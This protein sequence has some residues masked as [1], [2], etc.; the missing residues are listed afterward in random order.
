MEEE[1]IIHA[2]G[3]VYFNGVP[4]GPDVELLVQAFGVP[5]EGQRITYEQ[6]YAVL[7]KDKKITPGRLKGVTNGW[8]IRMERDFH[9]LFECVGHAFTALPQGGRVEKAAQHLTR[10][11]RSAKRGSRILHFTDRNRLTDLE[12]AKADHAQTILGA[13]IGTNH[14]LSIQ[15]T[16][17][18][19]PDAVTT[20][21]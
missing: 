8:R 21:K 6:V 4:I 9:V 15:R 20:K 16:N 2:T 11:I 1:K 10:S 5:E 18:S 13:M 7:E 3:K 12:R 19:L 14:L 17:L